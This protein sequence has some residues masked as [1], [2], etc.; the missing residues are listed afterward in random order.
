M[1]DENFSAQELSPRDI[2]LLQLEY[3]KKQYQLTKVMTGLMAAL[4]IVAVFSSLVFYQRFNMIYK[5]LMIVN[6]NMKEITTELA[7][8][9]LKN[10][11]ERLVS[12]LDS[13]EKAMDAIAKT[14]DKIDTDELN[15]SIQ[16][17]Q[18]AVDPLIRL[19][20]ALGGG[21]N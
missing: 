7:D 3:S 12:T 14:I 4:L 1:K 15:K 13:S 8:L 16:A 5:D 10:L 2:A 6:A 21:G 17:L 20:N 11:N 9:D 19:I 18:R